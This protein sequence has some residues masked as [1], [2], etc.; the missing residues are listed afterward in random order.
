MTAQTRMSPLTAMVIGIFGIGGVTIASATAVVLYSLSVVDK[1]LSVLIGIAENG[2]DSLPEVLKSLPDL[3]DTLAGQRMFDYAEELEIEVHFT[4][5]SR[6]GRIRPVMTVTNRGR[7]V[8]S[9]LALRVAAVTA[10]GIPIHEWTEV[11]ATPIALV[12][13]WRGPLM[14]GATRHVILPSRRLREDMPN[15]MT[16][17]TEISELR[18]W[19]PTSERS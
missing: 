8:V 9:T 6:E 3:A 15:N 16:A 19:D 1:N 13:E 18:I 14:P 11:V 17:M 10:S 12:D 5:S 7:E 4:P 2:V